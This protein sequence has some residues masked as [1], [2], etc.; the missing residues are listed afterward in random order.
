MEWWKSGML[1]QWSNGL[2]EQ[3]CELHQSNAPLLF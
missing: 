1:E 3:W 2:M